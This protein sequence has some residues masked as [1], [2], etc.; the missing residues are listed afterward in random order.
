VSNASK[1]EWTDSTWNPVRGCSRVSE[2]CR[3]CY[4]ERQAARFSGYGDRFD[5]YV[6]DGKWTGKVDLLKSKLTEPLRWR[7]PR[8]VFVNSMSDLFHEALPDEAIDR[9]FAVMARAPQHTFQVLTKRPERMRT[10]MRGFIDARGCHASRRLGTELWWPLPNVWLGVSC[11]D[12]VTAD[13]RIPI[14]LDT[15]AAV[16]FVSAEPLL[17][18]I[19]LTRIAVKF[20]GRCDGDPAHA[21][22]LF[23]HAGYTNRLDWAIVGGESGPGARPCDVGWIRS[24]VAQCKSAGVPCF[25][26]QLG[27]LPMLGRQDVRGWKFGQLDSTNRGYGDDHVALKLRNRK[28]GDPSEWPKDLRV[29]EF[30]Q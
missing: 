23:D 30:P 11:E 2:G 6:R 14:L 19:D 29:R 5:G 10:Y 21:S 16:R 4:A 25:V 26:K 12:Q 22:A 3:F 18:A 9:I 13:E 17:A 28:G 24:I 7:K 15:P 27:A 20:S 1:I 8:R